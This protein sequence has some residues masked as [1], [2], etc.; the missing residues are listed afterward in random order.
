ME[1]NFALAWVLI[2]WRHM[3][4]CEPPRIWTTRSGSALECRMEPTL[5]TKKSHYL[6]PLEDWEIA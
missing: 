6:V 5:A 2:R 3:D 4:M 1:A